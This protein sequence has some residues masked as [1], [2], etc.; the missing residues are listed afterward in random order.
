V[1]HEVYTLE[2]GVQIRMLG[3]AILVRPD[4]PADRSAS[5][6]VLYP[7]GAMEHVMATGTILAFGSISPKKGP[8]T[9]IPGLEVGLKVCYVRFLAE[10][11]SNKQIRVRYKGAI[12]IKQSDILLVYTPDEQSRLR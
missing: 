8:R 3:D 7:N 11:E 2:D 1:S 4:D 12:R 9:P 5:G 6:L 10:Q